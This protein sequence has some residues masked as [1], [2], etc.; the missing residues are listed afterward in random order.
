MEI[1]YFKNLPNSIIFC[2][3]N[4]IENNKHTDSIIFKLKFLKFIW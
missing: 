2:I 3:K 4:Y 1:P